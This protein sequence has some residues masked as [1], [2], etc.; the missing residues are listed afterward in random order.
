MPLLFSFNN[1]LGACE[2]C[3]GFGRVIEI[4][5]DK[6]IPNPKKSLA[7][8]AIVIFATPTGRQMYPDLAA[9]CRLNK[10]PMNV[11]Y[12]RLS[13]A[14][15]Q[16]IV[17]GRGEW[18]GIMGF[19]RWLEK[20]R[21]KVQAR[22]ALA[23]F[24]KFV[25]CGSCAG[26]RLKPGGLSVRLAGKNIAELF[27]MNVQELSAFFS[28]LEFPPEA[29]A[30]AERLL[31][32]V[33][34]RIRYLL[35]IGLEYL[36]LGRA[37]RTLSG[38]E[39][40]RINLAA[41]LGSSLTDTLYV[42]DEPSVGL[43]PRDH[44]RLLKVLKAIRDNG[45]TVVVVEHE[46]EVI[47][48]ADHVIDL[49]PGAGRNGGRVIYEGDVEGLLSSE[50][51]R[52]GRLLR[53]SLRSGASER[54]RKSRGVI[55]VRGARMNNLKGLD[56]DL[57]L[58]EL[59]AVAGVSGAG[60]S[61]LLHNILYAAYRGAADPKVERGSFDSLSGLQFVDDVVLVDQS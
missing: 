58:G 34:A 40:Q 53:R 44:H 51:S 21:Y 49:G 38:G 3:Q 29:G 10:I 15:R 32:E 23:R 31:L 37:T 4:D 57:P 60:K 6:V 2:T 39:T 25:T 17:D 50:H 11:A 42:L 27:R 13:D 46:P 30:V 26:A 43:H 12:G 33:R 20:R 19:F 28:R 8:D 41:A 61:T 45:N 14:Q 9:A 47:E 1:P 54:K 55:R 52:T 56:V 35:D 16:I 18:Y 36:T 22:V 24:R 5:L 59:V 48:Q 7:E